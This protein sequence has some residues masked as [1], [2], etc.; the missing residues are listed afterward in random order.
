MCLS[1]RDLCLLP[2]N[3]AVDDREGGELRRAIIIITS[4]LIG[5]EWGEKGV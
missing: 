2:R 3:E 1:M 5:V 4:H